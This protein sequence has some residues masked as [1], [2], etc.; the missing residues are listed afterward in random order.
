MKKLYS[1]LAFLFTC[2]YASISFGQS[3]TTQT[4]ILN[5]EEAVKTAEQQTANLKPDNEAKIIW[6]KDYKEKQSPIAFVYLHGFGAS[7]REG[8]PIMSMLSKQYN[9]NVYM[10]R[11]KEHGLN[12]EDNFKKLTPENYISTA[13]KALQIGKLLG[14]KII[15]V[16]TSTGGTLSLKLT[17]EDSSITGLIM[18]SPF[19]GLKNPAFNAILTP[20]GKAGF[21]QMNGGEIMKQNRNEEEAKYWSTSYHIDGYE[22]LIK[23]LVSTATPEMFAKVKAPT[24]V[25]YYYKNEK[26]Q[27]QVVSVPAILN[28]YENLGTPKDKKVKIAFPEA[29][30]HVIA[31]DLRSKD[32]KNVYNQTVAFIDDIILEKEHLYNFE[33]QGHRGARGLEPENTILAFKKALELKVNTLELDVVITKDKKVVVS[34]EPWLNHEITLDAKGNNITKEEALTFNIYKNKYKTLKKYDVGSLGNPKFPKQEKI[35]AHK[36]LLSEV[37][38]YAEEKNPKILYN[39]EIK[40]T[41]TDEANGFQPSVNEF[42]DLLITEIEKANLPLNRVVIQSFDPRVLEYLHK[43]YPDYTLSFLTYENDF[44]TNMNILSFVPEIYSPYYILLNHQEVKNIHAKNMKVFPWT[45]NTKD[46]MINVLKMGV[47]GIITDYPDIALPL[48]Q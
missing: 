15:L 45:V 21:I 5:I 31:C 9:A 40:S 41:P 42:S 20:E 43:T 25:G 35:E 28:M 48:R 18:Y 32:Y 26:E 4:T 23:M 12:R 11:L 38:T 1:F 37:I 8:E 22:A 13:K 16:S 39:I 29:G 36:P 10:S 46:E 2:F 6:A 47:D 17:S 14:E 33:L 7:N 3:L 44:E 19:I 34:H 24:F 30:N 27:D